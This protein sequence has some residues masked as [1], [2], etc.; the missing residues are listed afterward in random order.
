[1]VGKFFGP[2]IIVWFFTLGAVGVSH[3][4]HNPEILQALNPLYAFQFLANRGA[5]VFLAVGATMLRKRKNGD[6]VRHFSRIL[7]LNQAFFDRIWQ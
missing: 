5:G 1:M 4:V 7:Q 6:F 2:I 3:I